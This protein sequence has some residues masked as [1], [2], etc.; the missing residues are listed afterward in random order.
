MRESGVAVTIGTSS[1]GFI[2]VAVVVPSFVATES[3]ASGETLETDGTLV[4][5]CRRRDGGSGGGICV[6]G[7]V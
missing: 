5:P 3:L 4:G 6:G 1:E 2:V 7:G